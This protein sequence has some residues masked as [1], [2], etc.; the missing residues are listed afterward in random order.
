MKKNGDGEGAEGDDK[1]HPL[2]KAP[3]RA[4]LRELMRL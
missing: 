4:K 3:A 2:C 1:H